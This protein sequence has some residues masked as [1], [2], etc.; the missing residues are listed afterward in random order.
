MKKKTI[1]N[2]V[3]IAIILV[4]AAAG[5]LS[6]GTL[7]GWFDKADGTV[8][9][10][11]QIQGVVNLER[12]GAVFPAESDTVLRSGDKITTLSGASAVIVLGGDTVALGGSAELTVEN[13]DAGRFALHISG[14]EVFVNSENPVRLSFEQGE[15]VIEKATA[16]LS[17]RTG[18]Q[19]VSVFR[20]T[21]GTAQAGQTMEY[22]GGE[23]T[24][25]TMQ[26]ESLND[27]LAAQIRKVNHFV[28]LCY[29][30][31]DLDDLAAKRQ[32]AI[33]DILDGQ[34]T[35]TEHTHCYTVSVI[36][37]SCTAGGYTEHICQCGE[38]FTA[39]ETAALGHSWGQWTVVK[40]PTAEE[41]GLRQHKCW[42]CEA[43]EEKTIEKVVE[44]HT[45][46]Y[47]SETIAPTCTTEGYTLYTCAC[48]HS[49]TDHTVSATGHN[50]HTVLIAPTCEAQGYT[51]HKCA[52]GDVYTDSVTQATGHKWGGW[53]TVKE[54][55]ETEEGLQTRSC[56]I[57]G[58][59]EQ[60]SIPVKEPKAAGYVYL[61]IRCDT[62]LDNMDNLSPGKAEFVPADGIILPVVEVAFYEG[63]TVFDVLKR[64]CQ[65][66]GIQ[67]E[68]SWSPIYDSYY[69]ESI[70]NLYE[71][72]CGNES[73]WTYLVNDWSPNYGC[74]AYALEDGDAIVWAY[75]CQGL[76]SDIG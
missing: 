10:L 51:I 68:Y 24:V 3:M 6:V 34:T 18:A 30:N 46:D 73:G 69:I 22:V 72:D 56:E 16:A 31:Q 76:G 19:T 33:Q 5:M 15:S 39:E 65:I 42:N 27:F 40:E 7:Q 62:I 74:S 50:H 8:A 61:T 4:I 54:T 2:L 70:N 25:G 29:T 49:Y 17:V 11:T 41:E 60:A 38:R 9:V 48:G 14:G 43:I 59:T 53:K 23:I 75:T 45:H 20:G 63:E 21:V 13:P 32:Q 1:A 37:P 58:A 66:S 28:T 47:V 35:P 44:A 52:C 67:L 26:L 64:V 57:C 55:T 71:K 12:S 36:A